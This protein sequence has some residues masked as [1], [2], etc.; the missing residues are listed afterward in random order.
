MKTLPIQ[1]LPRRKVGQGAGR[2][3][4][5]LMALALLVGWWLFLAPSSLGGPATYVLIRGDSMLPTIEN[6]DLVILTTKP[7]YDVGD[8]VAYRVPAGEIGDG[9]IVVHRIV[10]GDGS[11]G[12]VLLGDN[13]AAPDPWHPTS[14]AIVGSP[15]LRIPALGR[16]IGMLQDPAVAA[17]LAAAA[18]VGVITLRSLRR[19]IPRPN[20]KDDPLAPSTSV[21]RRSGVAGGAYGRWWCRRAAPV[22]MGYRGLAARPASFAHGHGFERPLSRPASRPRR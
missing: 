6:G 20:S 3:A 7:T 11:T 4:S 14:D 2:A 8:V 16:L 15:W 1:H 18:S 13:N 17:S 9:K 21:V 10:D 5:A 12:L 22:P 19:P